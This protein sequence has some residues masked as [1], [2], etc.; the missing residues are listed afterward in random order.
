MESSRCLTR[1]VFCRASQPADKPGVSTCAA[2]QAFA[3]A[4]Q[5]IMRL[6]SDSLQRLPYAAS[7]RRYGEADRESDL[8]AGI[9]AAISGVSVLEVLVHTATLRQQLHLLEGLLMAIGHSTGAGAQCCALNCASSCLSVSA[10]PCQSGALP[11]ERDALQ[12]WKAWPS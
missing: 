8:G 10:G 2:A 7:K 3:L 4:L 1:L 11:H 6:H 5:D 12:A 9:N